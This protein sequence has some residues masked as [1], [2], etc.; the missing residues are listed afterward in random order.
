MF[1][2]R[3]LKAEIERLKGVVALYEEERKHIKFFSCTYTLTESDLIRHKQQTARKKDA[4]DR[5]ARY[6]G[7]KILKEFQPRDIVKDGLV[8]GY[9]VRILASRDDSCAECKH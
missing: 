1:G 7:Y 4:V 3:K 6:L 2:R 9:G 8:V 5:M